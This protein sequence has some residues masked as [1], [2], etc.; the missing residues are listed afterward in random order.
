MII[1]IKNNGVDGHPNYCFSITDLSCFPVE[2]EILICS[3]CYFTITNIIRD[4][5]IDYVHLTC[6]GY[7]LD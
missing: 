7:L 4:N 3:H 5:N 1:T 6:E 2:D